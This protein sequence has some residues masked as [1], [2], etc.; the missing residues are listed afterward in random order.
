MFL[1][2]QH[3]VYPKE[4]E[5]VQ[6]FRQ[7]YFFDKLPIADPYTWTFSHKDHVHFVLYNDSLIRAYAH[8]QLWP[9]NRAA[10]RIIVVEEGRRNQGLGSYLLDFTEKW[11]VHKSYTSLHTQ[12]SPEAYSFYK[13][14]GYTEFPFNDPDGYESDPLDIDVAKFLTKI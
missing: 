2:V 8:I 9:E 14:H 11:L 13:K 1:K 3:C 5:V 7:K 10:L 12:A 4:W 6:A